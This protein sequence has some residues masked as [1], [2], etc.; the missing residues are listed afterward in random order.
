MKI[1]LVF[2]NILVLSLCM[3]FLVISPSENSST[4][5]SENSLAKS[6]KELVLGVVDN[7]V[8]HGSDFKV[9]IDISNM[10]ANH[11]NVVYKYDDSKVK[12]DGPGT[13]YFENN[14]PHLI[15]GNASG[16]ELKLIA[17]TTE[18]ERFQTERDLRRQI[19]LIFDKN[20][21]DIPFQ[22]VTISNLAEEKF[23]KVSHY[24]QEK[25][26]AFVEE[27][28]ELSQEMIEEV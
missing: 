9:L 22:T 12:V 24:Q 4:S 11:I 19:K 25:A 6:G 3:Q 5:Y 18:N 26:K 17:K 20:Q 7:T 8:N 21:I 1:S 27:Q 16:V 28:K 14:I 23:Q 10:N 2:L 15:A 13:I